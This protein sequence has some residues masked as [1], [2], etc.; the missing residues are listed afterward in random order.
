MFS[1]PLVKIGGFGECSVILVLLLFNHLCIHIVSEYCDN[2]SVISV[3]VEKITG[4]CVSLGTMTAIDSEEV[5]N[6]S[7]QLVDLAFADAI[8]GS[9]LEIEMQ[10]EETG[11][12]V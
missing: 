8:E 4:N 10:N 6:V 12:N 5:E 9:A 2:H 7:R 11:M 1:V 3:Y